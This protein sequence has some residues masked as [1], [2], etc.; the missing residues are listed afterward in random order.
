MLATQD[1]A[2]G[3]SDEEDTIGTRIHR[4]GAR[5]RKSISKQVEAPAK[6]HRSD[7]SLKNI[8]PGPSSDEDP[9]RKSCLKLLIALLTPIFAER[10]P[11][12]PDPPADSSNPEQ[13]ATE[14]EACVF[15]IYAEPGEY[16]GKTP[17]NKYKYVLRGYLCM[18]RF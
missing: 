7:E 9:V 1:P 12:E 8:S 3:Q 5:K 6:R 4:R 2:S 18:K 13:Y 11:E 17:G 16:E 15:E 10:L 14:L